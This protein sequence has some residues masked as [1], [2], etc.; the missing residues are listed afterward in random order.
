MQMTDIVLRRL[1][2]PGRHTDDQTRGLHLW[3]KPTLK[4]YWIFRYTLNGVR[5]AISLGAYPETDLKSARRRAIEARHTLNQGQCPLEARNAKKRLRPPESPRFAEYSKKYIDVMRPQW[6][7]SKHV[8]QWVSTINSYAIP[9]LGNKR[10]DEI[11]TSHICAVLQ[12]IWQSVP[13]TAARLRGRLERILS[14]AATEGHRTP[15]N[16]ALWRGHLEHLLP[17]QRGPRSHFKALP[18][19]DLPSFMLRLRGIE[20][21]AALALQFTILTATRTSEVRLA[22]RSEIRGDVWVVP[23]LRMKAGREHQVPL[24]KAAL[25]IIEIAQHQAPKSEYLFSNG[26]KPL[27]GM[28]M[29][30]TTRRLTGDFTVHGFR[31]T[32]RDWVSEETAHN[33]EV[34]EMALAHTIHNKVEAAYR[35][36]NLLDRRRALMAD[37]AEYCRTSL[38]NIDVVE[39]TED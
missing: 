1:T 23:A 13:E 15:H 38:Q 10:L 32:F 28:A 33:P 3:V 7:C 27:S 21:V 20:G 36:G 25:E 37:W 16:P 12:P 14:A 4:S 31:S 8:N 26:E 24:T 17:S 35:R 2:K 22:K 9:V 29:L 18:Y 11:E 30:M 34:A 19:K 6:R 5:K 39:R